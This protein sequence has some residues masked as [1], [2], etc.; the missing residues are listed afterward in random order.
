MPASSDCTQA[1][2]SWGLKMYPLPDTCGVPDG[3]TVPLA[4][5][6]HAAIMK[7]INDN[8]A[9]ENGGSTPTRVAVNKA[10]AF[11]K[12]SLS[13]NA[14]YLL[15]A[16]DGLPNCIPGG[17]DRRASDRAAVLPGPLPAGA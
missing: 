16:T 11:L 13:P 7:A 3:A 4:T 15:L 5:G 10:T 12:S 14:K 1:G 8:R 6:N 9:Q 2:V 17:S